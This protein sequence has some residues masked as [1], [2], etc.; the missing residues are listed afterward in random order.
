MNQPWLN[1]G[2]DF[3]NNQS[4][5]AYCS[6][7]QDYLEPL[8]AAGGNSVRFWLFVEGD[9]IPAWSSDGTVVGTDA[10]GSLIEDVRKYVR[11]AASQNIFVFFTLWNGAVLKNQK[12]KNMINEESGAKLQSFIDNA[13]TPLV[14]ALKDEPGVGGWE[15]MNEAEGSVLNQGS[16]A[17]PCFDTTPLRGSGAGWAGGRIK[18]KNLQRFA[19]WQADAIHAADPKALVTQGTWNP[20]SNEDKN[21]F[22]NYWKDECLVKAGG[23]AG[24]VLDFYQMHSYPF[25][26]KWDSEAVFVHERSDYGLDDKPLVVGEFPIDADNAGFSVP[27][28]YQYAYDHGF[29]GAWGWAACED[30][31]PTGIAKMAPAL[32]ALKDSPGVAVSIGGIAPPDTCSCSDEAPDDRYT[33]AQQAS[34]G[35]CGETWMQGLCCR[36]CHSCSGCLRETTV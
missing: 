23:R 1:Y 33:C 4:N 7:R 11:S 30:D 29:D 32:Q 6:L 18:M 19:N 2:S 35:K 9:V 13:L 34:W 17:E 3:G 25:N 14:T 24:G 20:K 31:A 28:L 36:S 27:Q 10:A 12:V 16:D 5:G 22:R 21:G 15:I 8:A 26:N